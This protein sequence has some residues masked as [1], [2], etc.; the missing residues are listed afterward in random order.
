MPVHIRSD[1]NYVKKFFGRWE[2]RNPGEAGKGL[3]FFFSDE[4]GFGVSGNLWTPRFPEEFR[5]RKGYDLVPELAALFEDI[6]PRTPKVMNKA[7]RW[8]GFVQDRSWFMR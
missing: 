5:K 6:G 1:P 8:Q 3:N 2:D 7:T 4:F